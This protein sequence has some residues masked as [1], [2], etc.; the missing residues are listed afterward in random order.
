MPVRRLTALLAT[1]AIACAPAAALADDGGGAG[2]QQYQDPLAV[3]N[4]PSQKKSAKKKT[5]PVATTTPA[6][7]V[8][9]TT[10]S[11]SAQ[12]TAAAPAAELPR[13]GGPTPGLL[14]LAGIVLIASGLML[15]R[16]A[17]PSS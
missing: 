7:T 16:R 14:G 17:A 2:D 5:Q 8:A 13:T 15:R 9:G 10:Q 12:P 3:P 6:S 11:G 1:L 4:A